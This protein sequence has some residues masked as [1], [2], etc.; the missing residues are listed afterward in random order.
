MI[1]SEGVT[2]GGSLC[3][4]HC[5]VI[6]LASRLDYKSISVLCKASA[7]VIRVEEASKGPYSKKKYF[8]YL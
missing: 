6:T 8:V 4:I 2:E 7:P 3:S 5:L 1:I